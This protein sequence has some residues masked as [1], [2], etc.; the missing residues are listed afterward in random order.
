MTKHL[1]S[2]PDQI[3]EPLYVITSVFNAVRY[4]TRWKLYQD[5]V[6]MVEASGAILQNPSGNFKTASIFF[7]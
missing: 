7:F 5:F 1:F 6:R 4:R 2:R 3:K